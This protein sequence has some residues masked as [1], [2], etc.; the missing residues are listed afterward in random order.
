MQSHTLPSRTSRRGQVIVMLLLMM[1]V[2]AG[3]M[4]LAC[5]AVFAFVVKSQL[6]TAVD[7]AALA[8]S[9]ALNQGSTPAQQQASVDQTVAQMMATNFPAGLLETR[10]LNYD[11]PTIV[12]NGDGTRTVS[13]LGHVDSPTFFMRL[14][15]WDSVPVSARGQSLRRDVV[16]TLVL[17]RSGS[18]SRAPGS[19]PGL[20]AFDDLK[21]ASLEFLDNFDNSRDQLG[22]VVFGTSTRLDFA[23]STNFKS[24]IT[25]LIN[26]HVSDNSGTNAP[27]ALWTAYSALSTVSSPTALNVIVFFT[28]GVATTFSAN[29]AVTQGACRGSMV[30]GVA[31]TL[32]QPNNDSAKGLLIYNASPPPIVGDEERYQGGCSW[33]GNADL[34]SRIS[35]IP[36]TDL[37]GTSVFGPRNIP[38][39]SGPNISMRGRNIKPI[40]DNLSVNTATRARQDPAIKATVYS[41]GLGGAEYPADDELLR[42]IANDPSSSL[43]SSSDPTGLYVYAPDASELRAAF[44]RVA[45]QVTRLIN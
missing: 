12:D 17:D 2:L 21:A 13:V 37:H 7:A 28:D 40:A 30:S 31:Q 9:R 10:N 43:Y 32:S 14:F 45:S 42:M 22:L 18:M 26:S 6:T 35:A 11:P 23:P 24:S 41:I 39:M 1:I 15:G 25:S 44:R 38:F 20:T 27:D 29:F 19:A 4:G 36:N 34:R 16:L 5:D 33:N 8:A 3:F